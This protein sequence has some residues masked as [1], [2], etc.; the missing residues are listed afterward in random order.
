ME[1]GFPEEKD[2]LV[3]RLRPRGWY[4]GSRSGDGCGV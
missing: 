2:S 1:N 4:D 3:E